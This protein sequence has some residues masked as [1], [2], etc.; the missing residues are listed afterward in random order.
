MRLEDLG[1]DPKTGK[2]NQRLTRS[3]GAFVGILWLDHVGRNNKITANA[4]AAEFAR[5]LGY[6]P[7]AVEDLKDFVDGWK[8]D[9][10]RMQLHLLFEHDHILVLSRAGYGGGYWIAATKEEAD[11]FYDSFRKRAL[12][13]MKKA[14]RGKKPFMVEMVRQLS[15]EFDGFRDAVGLTVPGGGDQSMPIAIVDA[16]FEKMMAEPERF[17]ADLAKL[18]RKYGSVLLPRARVSEITATTK[19]LQALLEGL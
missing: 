8:R 3:E 2:H 11:A 1:V 9:V 15:F 13:G 19:K 4:L 7:V 16:L 18:G 17:S 6:G 14:A 5:A 12:T 10:R